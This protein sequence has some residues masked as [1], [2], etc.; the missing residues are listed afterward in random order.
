[1]TPYR[2][3]H[4]GRH[5]WTLDRKGPGVRSLSEWTQTQAATDGQTLGLGLIKYNY[6][7]FRTA[8][9]S[10]G[11][12][13]LSVVD[14]TKRQPGSSLAYSPSFHG[15]GP[16]KPGQRIIRLRWAASPPLAGCRLTDGRNTTRERDVH[17]DE[18]QGVVTNRDPVYLSPVS[19]SLNTI[20]QHDA[21]FC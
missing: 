18:S 7:A 21:T 17:W 16:S 8:Y 2:E 5:V 6:L 11:R 14:R 1:M 10:N 9:A 12:S 4:R 19:A 20:A 3:S 15:L 13:I